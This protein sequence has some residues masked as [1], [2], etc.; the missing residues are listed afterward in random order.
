MWNRCRDSARISLDCSLSGLLCQ[1]IYRV[2]SVAS[3]LICFA[4]FL[5]AEASIPDLLISGLLMSQPVAGTIA[6]DLP[7][8]ADYEFTN[9]HRCGVPKRVDT[10]GIEYI[11]VLMPGDSWRYVAC[12]P[13]N[14]AH[15]AATTIRKRQLICVAESVIG[16]ERTATEKRSRNAGNT[17]LVCPRIE[18]T[19]KAILWMATRRLG[20]V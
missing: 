18:K 2:P 20:L 6:R 13:R 1:V 7:Q 8:N 5:P 19:G 9:E 15:S 10:V 3:I 16:R 14:G 4:S 12:P 17:L 11:C